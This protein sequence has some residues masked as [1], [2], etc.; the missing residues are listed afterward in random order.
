MF[1]HIDRMNIKLIIGIIVV[2]A[3][4]AAAIF[5]GG[6]KTE[7]TSEEVEDSAGVAGDPIDAVLGFYK[8]YLAATQ[9]AATSPEAEGLLDHP[10]LSNAVRAYIDEN[11]DATVEPVLCQSVTPQ[12]IRSKTLYQQDGKA[13]VQVLGRLEG[14]KSSEQA[15][16]T[17]EVAN[18]AWRV[19]QIQ[20]LQGES[21]PEREFT[22]EQEGYLLKNVPAPLD[23][24]YWH[25]VFEQN[26]TGGH[27]VPLFID[28]ETI[29][30]MFDGREQTCDMSLVDEAT[31]ATVKGQMTEAGAQVQFI[32]LIQE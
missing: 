6:G 9:N 5:L 24:N 14:E 13:Q 16:V 2:I 17:L 4:I 12:K 31:R 19:T 10:I 30:T 11:K 32:E 27:T 20:C 15:V 7:Y 8:E 22:F 3:L 23:S 21:M 25:L 1:V 28:E 18:E 26:G 29:C